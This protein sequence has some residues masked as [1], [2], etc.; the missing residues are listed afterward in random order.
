MSYQMKMGF[1]IYWATVDFDEEVY[2]IPYGFTRRI[3]IY[4]IAE[5]IEQATSETYM[6]Y[7]DKE[8]LIR[9]VHIREALNQ[10]LNTYVSADKFPGFE[11]AVVLESYSESHVTEAEAK[12]MVDRVYKF[13]LKERAREPEIVLMSLALRDMWAALGF[14]STTAKTFQTSCLESLNNIIEGKY[15]KSDAMEYLHSMCGM[16]NQTYR[17]AVNFAIS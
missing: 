4:V 15:K 12:R 2:A 6:H 11:K 7:Q 10:E 1:T 8:V 3:D 14:W 9:K 16:F 17:D 5:S 13:S